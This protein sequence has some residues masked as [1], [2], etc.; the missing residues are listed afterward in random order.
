MK[1]RFNVLFKCSATL[2]FLLAF[3]GFS[4]AQRTI[5]GKVTD[6]A[7]SEPLIGANILVVGTSSGTV[8]D[9]DGNYELQIPDGAT[10]LRVTYTG[11]SEQEVDVAS[12][13]TFNISLVEGTAW[14]K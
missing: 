10:R 14:M 7:T 3:V 1:L 2:V 5:S 12:G 8:T 13:T 9:F 11:Y 4:Y 6:A